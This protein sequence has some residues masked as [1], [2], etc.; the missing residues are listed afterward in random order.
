MMRFVWFLLISA[1]ATCPPRKQTME[2]FY[3]VA[4][5]N[6]DGF[7]SKKELTDAINQ[8]LHWYE[9][10]PFKLFGGIQTILND[11]DA[12]HDTI[13]SVEESIQ[14]RT[15][16]DSCFKRRHTVDHFGCN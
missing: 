10:I 11:C 6:N 12:N 8:A 4:D 13:L 16:M 9:K 14:M 7:V 1:S 5:T 2:C 3:N 15:C